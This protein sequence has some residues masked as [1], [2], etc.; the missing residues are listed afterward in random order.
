MATFLY[1]FRGNDLGRQSPAE[2]QQTMQKWTVWMEQL[3]KGGHFKAGEPLEPAGKTIR[4][5]K[6][7]VTDGPYAE[8]KDFVGGYLLV[9]ATNLDHA[10]ELAHGCPIFERE[11]G[12]VEVR[13]IREMK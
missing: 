4:G 1:V 12:S 7:T 3:A 10:T 8:A 9:T 5:P 6:R 13:P 11:G 2:M